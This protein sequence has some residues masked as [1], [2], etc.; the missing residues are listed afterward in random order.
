MGINAGNTH[1]NEPLNPLFQS[2]DEA[3][4]AEQEEIRDYLVKNADGVTLWVASICEQR[5]LLCRQK[6]LTLEE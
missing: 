6:G 1:T 5:G 3:K 2:I 4:Q